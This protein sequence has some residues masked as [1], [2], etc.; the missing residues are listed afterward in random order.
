MGKHPQNRF[1]RLVIV[2]PTDKNRGST[3]AGPRWWGPRRP[4]AVI[5]I[6]QEPQTT[7]GAIQIPPHGGDADAF[8]RHMA[9]GDG[10]DRGIFSAAILSA[11]PSGSA[12][13]LFC[14]SVARVRVG[15][16]E[17]RLSPRKPAAAS[18]GITIVRQ[19]PRREAEDSES[20]SAGA[21]KECRAS[22][23][24]YI[25]MVEHR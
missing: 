9:R 25:S 7:Q 3:R 8:A 15:R 12:V 11:G 6:N 21:S 10:L 4:T 22:P 19:H 18:V 16:A 13:R 2:G 1:R 23:A 5:G 14:L 20:S 24:R 17:E